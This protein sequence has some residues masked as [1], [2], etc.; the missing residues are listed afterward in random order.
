V[1]RPAILGIAAVILTCASGCSLSQNPQSKTQNPK[2]VAFRNVAAESG[3]TFS[4]PPERKPLTILDA[5]GGGCAFLDYDKDGWLDILL[6]TRPHARLWRNE[7]KG[8]FTQVTE[9]A[10]LQAAQGHWRGCAVGDYDADGAPDVLLTG[11][12]RLALLRNRSGRFQDVTRE[13]NLSPTNRGHWALSAGFMPLGESG[14]LD[15]VLVNYVRFGPAE[16]QYCF[17]NRGIKSG[18]P[19]N[20]YKPEFPEIWE[21][22]GARFREAADSAGLGDAHGRAMVVAFADVNGDGRTDFYVGN[23]GLP[24]ELMINR[25]NL[26][27]ENH[28]IR[29]GAAFGPMSHPIA[30]MGADFAD[31]DRDGLV[32]L[33]VTAFAD[34]QYSLLRNTPNGMFEYKSDEAGL[35]GPT[36]RTLG[37]GA[38]FLDFDNDGWQDIAYA[39]GHVYDNAEAMDPLTTYRQP[40]QLFHS[41][42]G[43]PGRTF[44]DLAPDLGLAQP[45]VGR[46]SAVGDYDNDGRQDILI[47]DYEGV[48]LLLHNES[49]SSNNW[50]TLDLRGVEPNTFAYGAR[51][52][53]KAGSERWTAEVSPARSFL[54]SSDPRVHLGLGKSVSLDSLA[55]HWPNGKSQVLNQVKANRILRIQRPR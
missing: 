14:R 33:T 17:L 43:Q 4:W 30:A 41:R 32:D 34:E 26:R 45:I 3:L 2:S 9:Q 27:F 39:N 20:H 42:P 6:V 36:Y 28:G 23:D 37:F 13:A 38:T 5:I 35:T 15:L 29:S 24:A 21:N 49:E 40:I 10:G 25:G 55:I 46:G 12:K 54:S 11:Y 47:V 8:K 48:P 22:I 7:G 31:Y 44:T 19:V 1:N 51:I 18:C 52:E 50:L 53:A 16:H